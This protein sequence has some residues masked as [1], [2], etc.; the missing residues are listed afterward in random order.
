M[1]KKL[2]VAA[3]IL[4]AAFGGLLLVASLQP[5]E[6]RIVRSAEIA[7]PAARIFEHVDVLKRWD[8]W[9]PWAK[10][11]PNA[12]NRFEGPER[13]KGAIFHWSGND[14]VGAGSMSI[15]ESEPGKFVRLRLDF[16]KPME[17]VAEVEFRFDP[18]GTGTRVTWAMSGTNGLVEKV[19]CLF[20]DLDQMV[21]GDFERG[22]ASLKALSEG[23]K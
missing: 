16:K 3:G 11:D 18:A 13:G 23:A 17:D 19:F 22:L 5:T 8:A 12:V 15:L 2:L 10:K 7:A 1:K 20:M 6:F 14:Q 9:S 21:G 4:A